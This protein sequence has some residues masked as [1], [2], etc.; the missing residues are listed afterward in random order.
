MTSKHSASEVKQSILHEA[1]GRVTIKNTGTTSLLYSWSKDEEEE[2]RLS[3]RFESKESNND[4]ITTDR[5][6]SLSAGN[7]YCHRKEGIL[8]PNEIKT[9]VFTFSSKIP[10]IF[11]ERWR[12][13]TNP[14]VINGMDEDGRG[15]VVD[16]RGK[17]KKKLYMK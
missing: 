15:I 16:L 3:S 10:G 11:R 2:L 13:E 12:F 8:V 1:I 14:H 7:F 5:F 4:I 17:K 9:F 6:G